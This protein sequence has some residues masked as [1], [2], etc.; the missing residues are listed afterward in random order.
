M[1]KLI[2][3]LTIL[4]LGT[5]FMAYFYF[6]RI[7]QV[8]SG[9]A[10]ALN[11]ATHNTAFLFQFTAD[12]K[13]IELMSEQSIISELIGPE[14]SKELIDLKNSLL[15]N[16]KVTE[17]LTNKKFFVSK[18]ISNNTNN[19]LIITQ[20]SDNKEAEAFVNYLSTDKKLQKLNNHLYLYEPNDSVKYYGTLIEDVFLLSVNKDIIAEKLTIDLTAPNLFK[21][22]IEKRQEISKP[23]LISI[24][25]NFGLI[26]KYLANFLKGKLD[27][28]L[29]F[30]NK[31]KA[32]ADLNYTYS[33]DKFQ[34]FGSTQPDPRN[35]YISFFSKY[36]PVPIT[37]NNVLPY[38]TAS[39]KFFGV[40][41]VAKFQADL[42]IFFKE[43]KVFN[44]VDEV[45]KKLT[46]N[47]NL[48][49]KKIVSE[50]FNHEMI[51]FQLGTGERLGAISFKDGDKLNQFFTEISEQVDG[52]INIFKEDNIP[53]NLFGDA[54]KRFT[55]PY[56]VIKDN[57]LIFTP[58]L[59]TLK[60][61]LNDF[62]SGKV[63]TQNTDY[64]K[65]RNEFPHEANI[66]F[67]YNLQVG[68]TI[69]QR[70]LKPEVYKV[71]NQKNTWGNY[72][73]WTYQMSGDN[74]IFNTNF[75]LNKKTPSIENLPLTKYELDSLKAEIKL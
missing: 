6:S 19:I 4:F 29:A 37:I 41:N 50:Q 21:A 8:N 54:F 5:I 42:D 30:L 24:Y 11:I 75:L 27:G 13:F 66:V 56:F 57:N 28:E 69:I 36:K 32:F 70:D 34:L 59:S 26:D 44:K 72:L 25:V 49:F 71:F 43:Q 35:T 60:N 7:N 1:K 52:E 58:N 12:E 51:S 9:I 68:K 31:S 10:R 15:Q 47:Y 16:N 2:I 64:S 53:Y 23:K 74:G 39:Y 38:N 40:D 33:K 22:Y 62:N 46:S 65:F 20:L 3:L 63:L 48:D 73:Y 18:V 17:I 45:L 14:K 67:F 55:R 61:Y